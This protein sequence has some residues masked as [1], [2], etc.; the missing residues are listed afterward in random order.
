MVVLPEAS[1]WTEVNR[2]VS[3]GY[4]VVEGLALDHPILL[5][6]VAAPDEALRVEPME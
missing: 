1:D 2:D 5:F 4:P 6:P 3:T